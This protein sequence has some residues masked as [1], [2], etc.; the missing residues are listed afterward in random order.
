[1]ATKRKAAKKASK[2]LA[3]RAKTAQSP[4]KSTPEQSPDPPDQS[5]PQAVASQ[6]LLSPSAYKYNVR[7]E[8]LYKKDSIYINIKY[9]EATASDHW[10][11]INAF[12]PA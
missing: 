7:Y 11:N 8:I 3:K 9:C 6:P 2:P 5:E 4:P 12:D 1:M 10:I